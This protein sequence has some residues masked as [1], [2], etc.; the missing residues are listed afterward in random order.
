[1][2][3]REIE[4]LMKDLDADNSGKVSSKELLAALQGSGID[5]DSV[6]DFIA[7]QDKDHDGQLDKAEL[8]AFFQS[9]GC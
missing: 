2:G 8:K 6:K 3:S 9:L 5:M 4:E 1:M 7:A